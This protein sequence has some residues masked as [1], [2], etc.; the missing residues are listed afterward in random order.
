ML[1][2]SILWRAWDHGALEGDHVGPI[3]QTHG[4]SVFAIA[5][6]F[7]GPGDATARHLLYAES[8][9]R[10]HV[11]SRMCATAP[12]HP[13]VV[14]RD[15]MGAP[16]FKRSAGHSKDGLRDWLL[17]GQPHDPPKFHQLLAGRLAAAPG[18]RAPARRCTIS[19]P[20]RGVSRG[21]SS[22]S[23]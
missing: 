4:V 21:L 16:R 19:R 9:I 6:A 14:Y 1:R 22:G 15:L 12:D 2:I 7:T 11:V 8:T 5:V 23:A 10:T 20:C 18:T 17:S 3:S 13:A